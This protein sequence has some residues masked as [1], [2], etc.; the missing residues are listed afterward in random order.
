MGWQNLFEYI[1]G[2][3]SNKIDYNKNSAEIYK[4][5]RLINYN[6]KCF[7]YL[8]CDFYDLIIWKN[9]Y[10]NINENMFNNELLKKSEKSTRPFYE[11]EN[12]ELYQVS[13]PI[14]LND[15]PIGSILWYSLTLILIHIILQNESN[16][17][18]IRDADIS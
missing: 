5:I 7:K 17:D 2:V 6:K 14:T 1:S 12:G 15:I 9:D 13:D 3:I 16:I 18:Y 4:T 8:S 10:R 11:D